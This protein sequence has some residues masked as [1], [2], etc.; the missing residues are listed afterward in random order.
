MKSTYINTLLLIIILFT[1]GCKT[2]T[3]PQNNIPDI[4]TAKIELSDKRDP[5]TPYH[6]G[7]FIEHLGN[8][9]VGDLIDDCLWA[10]VLDDRKFFYPGR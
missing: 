7:M 4:I 2:T 10:E 8:A 1:N 5:I 3:T 9:D 6:Y